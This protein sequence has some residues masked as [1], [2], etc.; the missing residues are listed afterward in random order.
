MFSAGVVFPLSQTVIPPMQ[1]DRYPIFSF[2]EQ[3]FAD[4][5]AVA[6]RC[7]S[8]PSPVSQAG[9]NSAQGSGMPT[10][11]AHSYPDVEDFV[12]MES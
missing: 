5:L 2:S 11:A 10:D 12:L 3:C 6:P 4:A 8:E 1:P 7:T 9:G